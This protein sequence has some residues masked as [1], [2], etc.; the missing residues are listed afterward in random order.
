MEISQ[1]VE[2]LCLVSLKMRRVSTFAVRNIFCLQLSSFLV[3]SYGWYRFKW[4]MSIE[5]AV[6]LA[7][8]SIY[9]ATFR[10][11]ASGGV[12][13]GKHTSPLSSLIVG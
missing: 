7:R 11:G 1:K 2:A 4:D 8:R 6:E 9:H 13:S 3:C 10:D 12:A 5:D